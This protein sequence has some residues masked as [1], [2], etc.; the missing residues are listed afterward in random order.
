MDSNK[1]K[2]A[3]VL[4]SG[5]LDSTTCAYEA[6]RLGFELFALTVN[7][8]QRARRE[9]EA[10]KTIASA[11]GVRQHVVLPLDLTVWGGSALT[12]IEIDVP[13]RG[14]V[15]GDI[16]P[17]YV[18]ARNTILLS[19]ALGWAEV[20]DAE[21]IFIGVNSVDYS[22]YPDCRPE[23]I[24]AWQEVV[25]L[26]TRKTVLG[27]R[28]AIMSPLIKLSK[29]QIVE[30]ALALGVPIENTWSCYQDGD[31]PCGVCDSCRLRE[32]AIAAVIKEAGN[33]E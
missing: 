29:K 10:A 28:I 23:F 32:E 20:I 6:E 9:L 17:T 11:L 14:I 19:L 22:G 27:G 18:P 5:G 33:D 7:Y 8:G 25:N 21:A 2:K 4:M 31:K 26:A 24:A 13:N 12:D 15:E 16:P 30:R 1:G 3:V